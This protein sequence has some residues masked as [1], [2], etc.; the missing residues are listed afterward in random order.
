MC[1][2]VPSLSG[3]LLFVGNSSFNPPLVGRRGERRGRFEPDV[4]H[5]V[6][7]RP[8]SVDEGKGVK[9][10]HGS[11]DLEVSIRP[12]SVDEGKAAGRK[13]PAFDY[14]FQSAPRR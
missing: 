2:S 4:N 12:S 7:I 14:G 3:R 6:S 1:C 8:S 9:A 11:G 5:V 10:N 13:A